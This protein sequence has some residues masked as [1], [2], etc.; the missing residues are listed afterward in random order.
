[1]SVILPVFTGLFRRADELALALEARGY[2]PGRERT[3]M[4]PLGWGG[5]DTVGVAITAI[6]AAGILLLT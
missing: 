5:R 4:Y 2:R 3:A 1:M 6:W